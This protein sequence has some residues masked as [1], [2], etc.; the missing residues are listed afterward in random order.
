MIGAVIGLIVPL[1]CY[2]LLYVVDW[3]D[4]TLAIWPSSI[5]LL[6]IFHPGIAALIGVALS[7]CVNVVLYAAVGY[8][9]AIIGDSIHLISKRKA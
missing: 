9:V 7:V 3:G 1:T 6:A 8:F 2:A 4:W 5:M